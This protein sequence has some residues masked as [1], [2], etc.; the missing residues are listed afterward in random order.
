MWLVWLGVG[1]RFSIKAPHHVD[2]QRA[3]EEGDQGDDDQHT[4]VC[5]SISCCLSQP[6]RRLHAHFPGAW[7]ARALLGQ[8]RADSGPGRRSAPTRPAPTC[9]APTCRPSSVRHSSG[10]ENQLDQCGASPLA[11]SASARPS[12]LRPRLVRPVWHVPSGTSPSGMP[13]SGRDMARLL[14]SGPTGPFCIARSRSCT[15]RSSLCTISRSGRSAEIRSGIS[16][17]GRAER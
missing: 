6:T 10:P 4:R 9:P 16:A 5:S 13:T 7:R 14:D 11:N 2:Q 8:R 15:I 17:P 1:F 3:D 12:Y